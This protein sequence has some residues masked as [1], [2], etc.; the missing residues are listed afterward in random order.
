MV[1]GEHSDEPCQLAEYSKAWKTEEKGKSP[2]VEAPL[3]PAEPDASCPADPQHNAVVD[4]NSGPVQQIHCH[5]T[6]DPAQGSDR[7]EGAGGPG[8]VF[9]A[10]IFHSVEEVSDLIEPGQDLLTIGAEQYFLW[11]PPETSTCTICENLYPSV[12]EL[13]T[14]YHQYHVNPHFLSQSS[15]KLYRLSNFLVRTHEDADQLS[16]IPALYRCH[17]CFNTFSK[18]SNLKVHLVNHKAPEQMAPKTELCLAPKCSEMKKRA[19][20]VASRKQIGVE[21]VGSKQGQKPMSNNSLENLHVRPRRQASLKRIVE[22]DSDLSDEFNSNSENE[23]DLSNRR[24]WRP[25]RECK[26]RTKTL[27][28][29]SLAE[30]E[31]DKFD[32]GNNRRL[33]CPNRMSV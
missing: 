12:V 16:R 27:V 3:S 18:S 9:G 20:E 8:R 7:D 32:L 21:V 2:S 31:Y 6:V 19:E 11:K 13:E 28:A 17:E 15:V 33:F 26:S 29:I 4:T 5:K 22:I 10:D 24:Q 25:Q 14:H 30:Q 23:A 1:M